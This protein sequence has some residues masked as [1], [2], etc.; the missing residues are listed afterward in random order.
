MDT[1][2][3]YILKMVINSFLSIF[4]RFSRVKG[5]REKKSRGERLIKGDHPIM[6][7]HLGFF[8]AS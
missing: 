2:I 6:P 4:E 5:D 1:S 7:V 8:H 3:L